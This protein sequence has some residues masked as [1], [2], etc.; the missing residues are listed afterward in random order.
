MLT[1]WST[2]TQSSLSITQ[3]FVSYSSFR[4]LPVCSAIR[5]LIT[6]TH[7][8]GL[9]IVP[10]WINGKHPFNSA[11]SLIRA[12]NQEVGVGCQSPPAIARSRTNSVLVHAIHSFSLSLTRHFLKPFRC[13]HKFLSIT[14]CP[15]FGVGI[16]SLIYYPPLPFLG[17]SHDCPDP[18]SVALCPAIAMLPSINPI[19][20]H[21][22]RV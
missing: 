1:I 5:L 16:P 7:R 19:R 14:C 3:I 15:R 22:G 10:A 8:E 18:A 13:H 12:W 21:V 17:L 2:F 6:D 20:S 9:R 11:R 4:F